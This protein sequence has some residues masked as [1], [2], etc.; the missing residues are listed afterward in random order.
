MGS[1]DELSR[2]SQWVVQ[3]QLIVC[4]PSLSTRTFHDFHLL[5]DSDFQSCVVVFVDMKHFHVNESR[6]CAANV[7]NIRVVELMTCQRLE[8]CMIVGYVVLIRTC[9]V[10]EA[11]IE[12]TWLNDV[13]VAA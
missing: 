3:S 11:R 13:V 4:V 5:H 6:R 12:V 1:P 9:A 7:R 2:E 8:K 10:A